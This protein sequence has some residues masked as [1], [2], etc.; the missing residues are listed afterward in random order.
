[1]FH[2]AV[3]LKL[4]FPLQIEKMQMIIAS[5]QSDCVWWLQEAALGIY[6]P[7]ATDFIHALTKVRICICPKSKPNYLM[8][9]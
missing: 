6:K 5:I 9:I 1:M 4:S 7:T 2:S 8:T 3:T